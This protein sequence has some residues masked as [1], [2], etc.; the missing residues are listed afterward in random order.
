[1]G[2]SDFVFNIVDVV[3]FLSKVE[4]FIQIELSKFLFFFYILSNKR[5]PNYIFVCFLNNILH[6]TNYLNYVLN[7]VLIAINLNENNIS[8][9]NLEMLINFHHKNFTS[10]ISNKKN[11]LI[12]CLI[13]VVHKVYTK[14]SSKKG[15]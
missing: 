2:L 3:F 12:S 11:C 10:Y 5:K 15:A 14:C 9:I 6:K 13:A 8:G 1:M 7:K 4:K